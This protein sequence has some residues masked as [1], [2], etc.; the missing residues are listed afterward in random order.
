M[1]KSCI[2]YPVSVNQLIDK[3][4]QYASYIRSS[5]IVLSTIQGTDFTINDLINDINEELKENNLEE[6]KLPSISEITT[7]EYNIA[8]NAFSFSVLKTFYKD[9]E[10]F[11]FP[12][13]E[14]INNDY[15]DNLLDQFI[16]KLDEG[17]NIL[18]EN[19]QLLKKEIFIGVQNQK[20]LLWDIFYPIEI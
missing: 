20:S 1:T 12:E 3:Y 5:Y 15:I 11:N 9:F 16:V 7:F 14:G 6:I 18:K 4:K 17:D 8:V 2:I 10:N 13:I 19:R